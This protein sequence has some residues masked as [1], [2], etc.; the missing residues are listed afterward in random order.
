MR[1]P[2]NIFAIAVLLVIKHHNLDY[3]QVELDHDDMT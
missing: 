1:N 3:D 2:D